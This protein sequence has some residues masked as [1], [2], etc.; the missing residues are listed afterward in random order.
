MGELRSLSGSVTLLVAALL[1]QGQAP[2]H[3][4]APA[5]GHDALECV[6]AETFPRVDARITSPLGVARTRVYFKAHHHP[7]WYFTDMKNS[8][9]ASFLALLPKPLPETRRLDYYVYALD[10]QFHTTQTNEFGPD[11]VEHACRKDAGVPLP[12]EA[13]LVIGGTKIGQDPI[14]PGFSPHGIAAFVTVAGIVTPVHGGGPAPG[15]AEPPEGS[16]KGIR[17]KVAA[18]VG[19]AALVGGGVALAAAGGESPSPRP[20]A[21]APG[22]QPTNAPSPSPTPTPTSTPTPAPTPTPGPTPGPG[23][24]PTPTPTPSPTPM[25]S[26]DLSGAWSGTRSTTCGACTDVLAFTVT[27]RQ[28]GASLG[29]TVSHPPSACLWGTG[30]DITLGNLSG[31]NVTFSHP[32]GAEPFFYEGVVHTINTAGTREIDGTFRS[33]AG[34]CSGRFAVRR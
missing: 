27:L 21:V 31:D 20:Q 1:A 8:E 22:P 14:P 29:G 11:V 32:Q 9:A 23:P 15:L 30:G 4:V 16:A 25:P 2:S 34:S 12:P 17:R 24:S 6:K 18:A 28:T 10:A 19:G 26:P 13:G 7:D 3:G 5:I 33:S